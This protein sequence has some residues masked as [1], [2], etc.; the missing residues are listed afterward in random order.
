MIVLE[1][2]DSRSLESS[3][4]Y[5]DETADY[6]EAAIRIPSGPLHEGDLTTGTSFEFALALPPDALPNCRSGH[7]ELYWK[8]PRQP[9]R[10]N[11]NDCV[12]RP[13]QVKR[14]RLP[15]LRLLRGSRIVA[16]RRCG[17]PEATASAAASGLVPY[18]RAAQK[19]ARLTVAPLSGVTVKSGPL[20]VKST[21]PAEM[22]RP[23][24]G[25][26]TLSSTPSAKTSVLLPS[27]LKGWKTLATSGRQR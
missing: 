9:P 2:G 14:A 21:R 7:D 20:P 26:R 24:S 1:G 11:N 15:D 10:S 6:V 19:P 5:K 16:S 17:R 4:E 12:T 25:R 22:N 18:A 27:L 8:L 13:P 3:L 23:P